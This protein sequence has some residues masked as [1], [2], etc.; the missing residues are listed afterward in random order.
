MLRLFRLVRPS[1]FFL[2]IAAVAVLGR[3]Q[4]LSVSV[5]VLP[6]SPGRLLM[7]GSGSPRQTWSF[8]DSYAGVL[9][10]GNRVR[11]F[12]LFDVNGKQIAVR[13]IAPGQFE[14]SEPAKNFKYEIELAP[15]SKA[16]DAAFIS[17]LTLDRGLLMFG[18]L[19]P[20]SSSDRPGTVSVRLILPSGWSSYK[21]DTGKPLT[22]S[23]IAD[24]DQIVVGKKI[25]ASTR[26]ILGKPFTILTDGE[27]AFADDDALD[28]AK[29]VLQ[30]HSNSVAPLPCASASLVLLP[31]PQP[32]AANKWSAQ[33]RGCTVTM[34]MGRVPS[35]VGATSQLG[36]ALT[37]ELFHFW[38]P[39]GLAVTPDYDW[40][41]EGFTMYQAARAAVR[42]DLLTFEQ[43]L[44]AIADA[45]GGSQTPEAQNL[46][47]IEASKQRWT[48]G[49]STV[50]SKA[51]VI[52]FLYDLNLRWQTKGKRSLDD[53]YRNILRRP[54]VKSA[55][56]SQSD[57]DGNAMAVA[58]LRSEMTDQDFVNRFV[59]ARGSIDLEKELA[60]FGLHVEKPGVR[61]HI[62]VGAQL[63]GR[64]RDLLKQLGYNEPRSH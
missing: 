12:Q 23:E 1:L 29:N 42:L 64:Q 48:A 8:R 17:W 28:V 16:S 36:L 37:H 13:R 14:A 53:V 56:V 40:F 27:W 21:P 34:V 39:N 61:N 2:F 45:Y 49:A 60:P 33:T 63:T 47:L 3:A 57:A 58:A 43:F 62:V 26:E 54:I 51:M 15:A 41:Y 11:G 18:D 19:L 6:G 50:Y 30:F 9:G 20:E 4:S 7:Q 38:V 24:P 25:R 44:D 52:A 55:P 35:K 46:S 31:F 5:E 22:S 32:A 59:V 10:L